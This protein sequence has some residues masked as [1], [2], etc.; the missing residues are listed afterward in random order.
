MRD[1]VEKTRVGWF[2]MLGWTACDSTHQGSLVIVA[3]PY[4]GA[5]AI[6]GAHLFLV[7][8]THPAVVNRTISACSS[9][10]RCTHR[11]DD[12]GSL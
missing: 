5:C 1:G 11:V 12:A 6:T 10:D 8:L 3:E 7:N 2:A 9:R 4:C